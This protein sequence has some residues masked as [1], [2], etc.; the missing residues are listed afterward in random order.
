MLRITTLIFLIALMLLITVSCF[1]KEGQPSEAEKHAAQGLSLAN[2]GDFE[3]AKAEL[4]KAIELAP[5]NKDFQ[6]ALVIVYI[7]AGNFYFQQGRVDDAIK[8]FEAALKK[9]PDNADL[10]YNLGV[11]YHNKNDLEK[12]KTYY[13]KCLEL[14]PAKEVS[15]EV[16]C[17]L[18]NLYV[19]QKNYEKARVYYNKY[20][21]LAPEGNFAGWVYMQ[22]G[23]MYFEEKSYE[24]ASDCYKNVIKL[25]DMNLMNGHYNLGMCYLETG[26][27][28]DAEKEFL[29]AKKISPTTALIYGQ[30]G[31]LYMKKKDYAKAI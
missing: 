2:S 21:E 18:G 10:N 4:K 26:K 12:A 8:E 17:Y 11:I 28:D 30:L 15:E 9:K 24:K 25:K 1:S 6:E 23:N 29:E 5:D 13:L 20:I 14:K 19:S 16:T 7:K 27:L 22:M 31:K 3:G